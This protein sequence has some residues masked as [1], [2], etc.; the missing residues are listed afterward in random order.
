MNKL[1]PQDRSA[2]VHQ[3]TFSDFV[4]NLARKTAPELL[5]GDKHPEPLA[6]F[7]YKV[8]LELKQKAFQEFWLARKLPG[9]PN[10]IIASPRPRKYRTTSKRRVVK[11]KNVF[12][13]SFLTESNAVANPKIARNPQVE[14]D[15][16]GVIY[17]F[18]LSK[19]NTPPYLVLAQALNY[20]I[21]RGDYTRF[22]VLFN[23]HR[24]NNDVV[25]KAKLL[26]DHLQKLEVK[27]N[28]AFLYF[29]PSRSDFYFEARTFDGPWKL[30][31]LFGPDQIRIKVKDRVY[32]F[33]PTSFCQVNA[34]IL[35]AFLDEADRLLN[36]KKEFRLLDLYS[37]FG[38]FT[39]HL[40]HAYHE[41]LGVDLGAESIE[42]GQRM[43]A[44]EPATHC[45]FRSGRI[46]LKSLE[47]LLP[48]SQATKS[49][50]MLLD[51]PRQGTEAGVIA[52]LAARK[53]KRV[54]HIFCDLDTLPK[55]VTEWNSCGYTVSEVVPLDMFPGTDNLEVMV[56]FLPN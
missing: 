9:K 14:P 49:E 43:A 35:P 10:A 18:V 56:L 13:L 44:A 5:Q 22:T 37:G 8:E 50:V 20:I 17:K 53:P 27:V 12:A 4:I 47:Q 40:G 19:L 1:A 30:K 7:D 54:L 31:N 26:G 33:H 23:V 42:S 6:R 15:E 25:R 3:S 39:L 45:R 51:P 11:I 28:S 36:P 21:I 52:A 48:A 32:A 46:E 38:F 55:E 41:A 2:P 29:D 16:H 34:S 24:L